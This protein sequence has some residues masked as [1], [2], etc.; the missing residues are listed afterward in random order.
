MEIQVCTDFSSEISD[1]LTPG[2]LELESCFGY[3]PNGKAKSFNDFIAYCY[4][5]KT[6]FTVISPL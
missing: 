1:K 6:M 3:L 5:T 4:F 2:N